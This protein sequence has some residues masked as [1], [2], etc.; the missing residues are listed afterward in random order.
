MKSEIVVRKSHGT[1]EPFTRGRSVLP[2]CIKLRDDIGVECIFAR[3]IEL[4]HGAGRA[5]LSGELRCRFGRTSRPA[6]LGHDFD[7]RNGAVIAAPGC[8]G[9]PQSLFCC[10]QLRLSE[11]VSRDFSTRRQGRQRENVGDDPA[12]DVEF[13][14]CRNAAE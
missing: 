4:V 5:K 6:K 1:N 9:E 14:R 11:P 3:L 8:G 10:A 13:D 12:L 2:R 7:G